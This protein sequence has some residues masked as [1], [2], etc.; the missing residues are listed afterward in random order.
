[1]ALPET[2]PFTEDLVA[3]RQDACRATVADLLA[4][5]VPVRRIYRELFEAALHEVGRR[6]ERG[7][8]TVAVEHRATAIVEELLA[9][10]YPSAL[11]RPAAGRRAVVSCAADEF[12]QVGG[13]IV[14]DTLEHLGWQVD[15]LGA[16]APVERVAELVRQ[17][18]PDLVALSV[19]IADH[20]PAAARAVAAVR[21]EDESVAI[22]VGGQ[23]FEAEG[24]DG[25]AWAARHPGVRHVASLE[26][27]EALVAA[28][29]G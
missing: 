4:R 5:D 11:A 1:V 22:V 2:D 29:R 9:M 20:L 21:A 3:G 23:A 14:A 27:L 15:F 19:S 17:R 16:G 28:W 8:V 6:W 7:Q 13:R 18:G 25:P 10:V 26:A 24:I 12:H